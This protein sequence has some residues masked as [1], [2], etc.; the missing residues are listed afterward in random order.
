[1]GDSGEAEIVGI[2]VR[3]ESFVLQVSLA[4]M[5]PDD[6]LAV[7][8]PSEFLAGTVSGLLDRVFPPDEESRLLVSNRFDVRANPDLPEIY[9]VLLAVCD[10]WR[11]WRCSLTVSA[12]RERVELSTPVSQLVRHTDGPLVLLLRLEQEYRA[13]EYAVRHGIWDS[14][15]E[16]LGWMRSLVT[17]YFLDKH[18]AILAAP[19]PFSYGPA[20]ANALRDLEAQGLIAAPPPENLHPLP[21]EGLGEGVIGEAAPYAIAPEGRRFIARLLAETESY[22]DQY[23]HYQDTLADP[24]S[25]PPHWGGIQG[26]AAVEFGTGRGV[27]LR[28]EAFLAE[29]LDPLRTVF[30]LRLYDG[31]LDSRLSDWMEAIENEELFE[32]LLEPVVNRHSLG[33]GEILEVMEQGHAWLEEQRE[34]DRREQEDRDLLRRAGG[35]TP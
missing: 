34:Q 11:D 32:G 9:A 18:E 17:L 6:F 33:H 10:E 24:L 30:L 31:T 13:V 27:D 12:H 28:V 29:G 23:D 35:E 15:D 26:G 2:G 19:P 20:L 14:R 1:M 8:L 22:I 4:G 3:N 16:L 21:G 7:E 5:A 25:P